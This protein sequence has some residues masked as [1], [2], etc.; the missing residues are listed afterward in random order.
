MR[1][2]DRR[3]VGHE[4]VRCHLRHDAIDEWLAEAV[5]EAAAHDDRLQVEKV[6]SRG[7]TD[8]QRPGRVLD[9]LRAS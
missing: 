9:Q 5:A 3:L 7:K 8:A 1:S 2:T 4:E 6:L